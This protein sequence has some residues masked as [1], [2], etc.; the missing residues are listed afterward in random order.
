MQNEGSTGLSYKSMIGEHSIKHKKSQNQLRM[1]SKFNNHNQITDDALIAQEYKN[2]KQKQMYA[3][4]GK[5]CYFLTRFGKIVKIH[6]FHDSLLIYLHVLC[7]KYC[8]MAISRNV[9]HIY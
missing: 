5:A 8:T 9:L 7:F 6:H 4:S 2:N 3:I 1:T